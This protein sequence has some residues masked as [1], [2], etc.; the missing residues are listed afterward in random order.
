VPREIAQKLVP[1]MPADVLIV[2]GE[3]TVLAY[4]LGPIKDRLARAMRES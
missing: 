2:T 3:R 1:G 4:F